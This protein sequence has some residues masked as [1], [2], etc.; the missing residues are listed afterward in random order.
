MKKTVIILIALVLC[1]PVIALAQQTGGLPALQADLQALQ[2]N[3]QNQINN[4]PPGPQGPQG[5]KGDKGDPGPQGL[6][7]DKGDPGPAG[8]TVFSNAYARAQVDPDGTLASTHGIDAVF[9]PGP[10]IYQILF[11]SSMFTT[12]PTCYIAPNGTGVAI[13]KS[14]TG[15]GVNAEIVT[16]SPQGDTPTDSAFFIICIEL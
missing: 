10:G 13:V 8:P 16:A 7:G 2:A 11:S 5:P 9:H 3:L 6:K 4:I 15:T 12:A 14:V 1:I